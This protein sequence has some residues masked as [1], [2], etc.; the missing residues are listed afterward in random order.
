M[1]LDFPAIDQHAHNVLTPEAAERYSFAAAFTEAH[2]ADMVRLHAR[3]T[4]FFRRSLRDIA[5]LLQCEPREEA[6]LER[7]RQLGL[8]QITQRSLQAA[9]LEALILDDGFQAGDI[10]PLE[11]HAQFVPVR[12]LLRL[13]WLAEQLIPGCATFQEFADRFRAALEAPPENVVGFKSIAAYRT[14]LEITAP[15]VEQAAGRFAFVKGQVPL[16]LADKTMIDYLLGLALEIAARR[17]LPVQFHTGFGDPDL[18]LRLANPLCLRAVLEEPRFRPAPIVLLHA[19]YPFTR[20]AGYL[21]SVYSQVYLDTS[22]AVP[23]LSVAGMRATLQQLLELAPV[24]KLLY[25]S[26]AHGIPE[27][28]YLAAKHGREVLA[29]ALE[30][31]ISAGDLTAREADEAGTLILG[32][33][34][35]RLYLE[36]SC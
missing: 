14:G 10:L 12:R 23:S 18:D 31:A 5:E 16:R 26:D 35:R 22:L 19:S 20:E 24:S 3:N 21:A 27:L 1:N 30:Q 11:W 34:A 9:K 2:D 33:N 4:L 28:Y 15:T 13:E 36:G 8:E 29:W 17:R 25:S 32:G 7:R 6:I